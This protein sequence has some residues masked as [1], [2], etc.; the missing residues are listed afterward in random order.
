MSNLPL[1]H[2]PLC[3]R[4]LGAAG[5]KVLKG[6][7]KDHLV[8]CR[9][10][11]FAFSL[12]DPTAEDY[13]RVYSVYDYAAEDQLR[14]E[15]NIA[16]ERAIVRRLL[17]YRSS[18]RVLDV[19]AGA[20]RFLERFEEQGFECHATEFSPDMCAYL[21]R[22]G[23]TTYAGGLF[24]QGAPEAAFDIVVFTEIIEHNNIPGPVLENIARLL[25]P[26][27]CIYITTPNFNSLEKRL[28]GPGWG[29]FMWPEHITYWTPRHLDRALRQAGFR[30]VSLRTQNIS[31]YRIVQA[32]KR[33][34]LGGMMA[35]VSEQQFSDAAQSKVAGSR[36]LS[37]LK[38]VVNAGLRRTGLGSS[39]EAVYE[40][41]AAG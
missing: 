28:L 31:P 34:R 32:L 16:K 41:P 27:G 4:E 6:Y 26:G 24:P 39:I 17:P 21:E 2:C 9:R 19:A 5:Y 22:K 20:G 8:R 35:G 1:T 29:M 30:K 7:E 11:G 23:F 33:G 10:C 14:T 3:R 36:A 13:R 38:A 18:G 37:A 25:R 15:L 12:L 40:R